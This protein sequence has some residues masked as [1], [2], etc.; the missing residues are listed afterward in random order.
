MVANNINKKDILI[1]CLNNP[2]KV[3]GKMPKTRAK[4]YDRKIFGSK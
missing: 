1:E 3:K 2:I 4:L